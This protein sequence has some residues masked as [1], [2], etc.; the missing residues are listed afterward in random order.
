MKDDTLTKRLRLQIVGVPCASCILPIRRIL[1][2]TK[3]IEWVGASVMLDLLLIDY[4]PRT[5][6]VAEITAAIKKVGYTAVSA[7]R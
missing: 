7:A 3:G 6:T 2:K 5:I 4:D 1:K